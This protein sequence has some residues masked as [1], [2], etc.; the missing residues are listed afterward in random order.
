MRHKTLLLPIL[1]TALLAA[2]GPSSPPAT[3]PANE[4][5]PPPAAPAEDSEPVTARYA[6]QGGNRVD[7][8]REGRVARLS[9]SDGRMVR[10][11]EVAGSRPRTWMDVGLRFV[12]GDD[13]VE[14]GQ[15]DGARTL[16]CEPAQDD[17]DA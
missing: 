4:T 7:L 17:A 1:C 6:C 12:V 8:I 13:Y 9:L 15:L 11:G 14:L 3:A 16:A 2:C 10:L 5:P